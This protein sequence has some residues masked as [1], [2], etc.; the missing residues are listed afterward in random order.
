MPRTV[1]GLAVVLLTLQGCVLRS[2]FDAP[3]WSMSQEA[4]TT[5]QEINVSQPSVCNNYPVEYRREVPSD[6]GKQVI[7]R[8]AVLTKV[9]SRCDARKN[10]GTSN[11]R[12]A[13]WRLW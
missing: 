7:V 11:R 9:P 3:R 1:V 13:W 10:E 12:S 8:A 4:S 6:E 2:R 5:H